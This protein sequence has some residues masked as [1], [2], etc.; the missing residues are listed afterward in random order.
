MGDE[1]DIVDAAVSLD[2]LKRWRLLRRSDGLYAYEE[3]TFSVERYWTGEERNEADAE[4]I[5]YWASTY[6]SGL[7]DDPNVAWNDA[8]GEIPWLHGA[9]EDAATSA[10]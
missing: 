6:C 9:K 5:E 7:F 8:F 1:P 10:S 4:V 2:G 3:F